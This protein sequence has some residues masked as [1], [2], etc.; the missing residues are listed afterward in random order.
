MS[1]QKGFLLRLSEDDRH[2]GRE[3]A[4]EIGYSENRLYAE[5]IHDGLLIQEQINYYSALKK[6][7]KTIEKDEVLEI[8][9]KSPASPPEPVDCI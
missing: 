1:K 9:A 4:S 8:L 2:R 7:G 5:I 6:I 3:L